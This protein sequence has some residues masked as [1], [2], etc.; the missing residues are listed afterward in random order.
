MKIKVIGKAHMEGISKKS[1]KPYNFNQVHYIGK[2]RGVEG[3]A[4]LTCNLDPSLVMFGDIHVGSEYTLE[5]DN[6]GYPVVFQP[7]R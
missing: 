4:A 2:A 5:F 7:V 3:D 6:R 1:G